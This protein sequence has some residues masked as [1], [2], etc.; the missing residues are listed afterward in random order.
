MEGIRSMVYGRRKVIPND[1][2]GLYVTYA[3]KFMKQAGG[4]KSSG[5]ELMDEGLDT[6]E[7]VIEQVVKEFEVVKQ[8]LLNNS[9][10]VDMKEIQ[11]NNAKKKGWGMRLLFDKKTFHALLLDLERMRTVLNLKKSLFIFNIPYEGKPSQLTNWHLKVEFRITQT[12]KFLNTARLL[13]I[14]GYDPAYHIKL[15][16]INFAIGS[17]NAKNVEQLA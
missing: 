8:V 10:P 7:E 3:R 14:I 16:N 2:I 1:K 9:I 12:L 11:Q 6:K 5:F 17:L 4:K 13:K 15:D